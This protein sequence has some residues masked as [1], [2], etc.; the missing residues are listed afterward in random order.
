MSELEELFND[1][2]WTHNEIEKKMFESGAAPSPL[3]ASTLKTLRECEVPRDPALI[4]PL[5]EWA[6]YVSRH[7]ELFLHT[8]LH[9]VGADGDENLTWAFLY[10][11]KSPLQSLGPTTLPA[12]SS[13]GAEERWTLGE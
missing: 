8:A 4:A 6:G 10:A 7:R 5:Q 3:K 9:F 2:V 13:C 11:T 12:M 1:P